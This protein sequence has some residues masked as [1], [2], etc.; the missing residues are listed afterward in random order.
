MIKFLIFLNLIFVTNLYS[1]ELKCTFEEVYSDGTVQNGFFL[2]K[3]KNYG[4]NII[5]RIYLPFF[6]IMKDFI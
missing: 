3:D 1:F 2:I 5:Q 4:M 6:I